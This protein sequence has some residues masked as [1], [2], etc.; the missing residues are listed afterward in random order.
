VDS[1]QGWQTVSTHWWARPV[2]AKWT[3]VRDENLG[4]DL[5]SNYVV[6]YRPWLATLGFDPIVPDWPPYVDLSDDPTIDV[7]FILQPT[8]R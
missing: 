2:E 3:R 8:L 7:A 1:S 5:C 6:R 4:V